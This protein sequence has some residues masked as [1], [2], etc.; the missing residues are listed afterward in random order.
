[1]SR[2]PRTLVGEFAA[3]DHV[4]DVAGRGNMFLCGLVSGH[5]DVY[6][7]EVTTSGGDPLKRDQQ[8][9]PTPGASAYDGEKFE[10]RINFTFYMAI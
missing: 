4:F 3:E 1:M 2:A 6:R 9:K 8:E 5:V 7:G 10:V